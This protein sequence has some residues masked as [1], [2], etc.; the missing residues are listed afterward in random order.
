MLK[1]LGKSS[2]RQKASTAALGDLRRVLKEGRRV[3]FLHQG[4]LVGRAVVVAIEDHRL[5]FEPLEPIEHLMEASVV[6]KIEQGLPWEFSLQD[7]EVIQ[8]GQDT[9]LQAG[10]PK[11]VH[12][13]SRRANFR[14]ATPMNL[15][16]ELLFRFEDEAYLASVLD[17]SRSGAQIRLDN[18]SELPLEPDQQ[19]EAAELKLGE[20][21]K[22]QLDFNLRWSLEAGK[23]L[24]AGVEFA[25][26]SDND[27]DQIH[28]TVCEIERAMIRK[29]K[30]ID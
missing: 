23:A 10:I 26:L 24:R 1:I 9:Y 18:L 6:S 21:Q 22:Y 4:Q 29:Q 28:H 20:D 2:S 30:A 8:E 5:L 11:R 25:G 3:G 12:I 14:I 19:V 7:L 13:N 16:Y 17:L 15:Q 27:K